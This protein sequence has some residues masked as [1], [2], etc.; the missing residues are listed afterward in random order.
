MLRVF[1]RDF[2]RAGVTL[3]SLAHG[4]YVQLASQIQNLSYEFMHPE[5]G[6]YVIKLPVDKLPGMDLN[7]F[8][9]DGNWILADKGNEAKR[10]LQFCP[11]EA[12]RRQ[13]YLEMH[14]GLGRRLETLDTVLRLR[15]E[16]AN[17]MGCKSYSEYFLQDKMAQTPG[18]NK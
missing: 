15:R 14:Q 11:E 12:T 8:R 10:I 13:V 5:N 17:L 4:A 18:N 7:S 1:H 2:Q 9:R 6:D 16:M 3:N